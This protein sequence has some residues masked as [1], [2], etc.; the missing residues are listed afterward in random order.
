MCTSRPYIHRLLIVLGAK[1]VNTIVFFCIVEVTRTN[2]KQT[3][4]QLLHLTRSTDDEYMET[5]QIMRVIVYYLFAIFV[6][7]D[8]Y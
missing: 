1:V 5:M 7:V 2:K 3:R 6:G 4:T 8:V